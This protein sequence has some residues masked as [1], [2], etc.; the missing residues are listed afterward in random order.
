VVGSV[1][2]WQ[3]AGTKK[4]WL[5][6]ENSCCSI[7]VDQFF[8][9][10]KVIGENRNVSHIRFCTN[11]DFVGVSWRWCVVAQDATESN[12]VVI[13]IDS[14]DNSGDHLLNVVFDPTLRLTRH[15]EAVR[16]FGTIC[17]RRS[18]IASDFAWHRC[19]IRATIDAS[20]VATT[21]KRRLLLHAND[22]CE[23]I[24]HGRADEARAQAF[25]TSADR[26]AA[27]GAVRGVNADDLIE[28]ALAVQFDCD[29]ID[30]NLGCP[31]KT[32]RTGNYGA[33]LCEQPDAVVD[34][35]RKF[36]ASAV[37][38]PLWVKMRV[39]DDVEKTVELARRFEAAGVSLIAVH[40]RTRQQIGRIVAMPTCRKIAAVARAVSIP[41]IANGNVRRAPMLSGLGAKRAQLLMCGWPLLH[42]DTVSIL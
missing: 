33:F 28:S 24:P 11:V 31:Q 8:T 21:R 18:T 23:W 40:G 29:A 1:E 27:G 20:A 36:K 32:A 42:I 41:V 38:L 37:Q 10:Q 7:K 15:N 25:H 22:S 26:S 14:I 16:N 5:S 17:S 13:D 35:I 34:M 2:K 3:Q 9:K 30:I 12:Y 4:L 19:T 39:Y 6:T